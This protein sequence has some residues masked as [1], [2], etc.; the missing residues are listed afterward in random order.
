MFDINAL[1]Q[2][3]E[4]AEKAL[5]DKFSEIRGAR[6]T[7]ALFSKL[8]IKQSNGNTP[9]SKIAMIDQKHNT[10]TIRLFDSANSNRIYTLIQDTI[11]DKLQITPA[12]KGDY[13]EVVIPALTQE[14]RDEYVKIIH[15]S[16][17]EIKI[18]LRNVR[19]KH[20]D[21]VDKMKKSKEISENEEKSLKDK[22]QKEHD[23]SILV[24][25]KLQNEKIK[26]LQIQ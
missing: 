21:I 13:V 12:I 19:Q 7:V 1:K 4:K 20:R 5:V 22:I 11:R 23:Q 10:F 6:P 25:E 24:L 8:E 2:E 15:K 18:S 16:T 14:R 17:E 3:L 9:L 26:T